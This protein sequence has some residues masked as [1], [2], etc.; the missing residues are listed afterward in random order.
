MLDCDNDVTTMMTTIAR[1]SQPQRHSVMSN[2]S[3]G[4]TVSAI[5]IAAV[6]VY[7]ALVVTRQRKVRQRQSRHEQSRQIYDNRSWRD[8]PPPNYH[9]VVSNPCK[10]PV[11]TGADQ[12]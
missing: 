4:V 6:V 8:A 9:E 10:Y 1:Q 7:V 3:I 5:V 11:K 12:V 2:I